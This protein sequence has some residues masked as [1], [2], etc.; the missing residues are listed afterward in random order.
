MPL[1]KGF[2]SFWNEFHQPPSTLQQ[3]KH[4]A[5]VYAEAFTLSRL[6]HAN[7]GCCPLS[8]WLTALQPHSFLITPVRF[9]CRGLFRAC[10]RLGKL[11]AINN[12]V[13]A[14]DSFRQFTN[15]LLAFPGLCRYS[16][17]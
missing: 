10:R 8:V 12:D 7:R 14:V 15:V 17:V 3:T 11:Q 13:S 9:A 2:A 16:S 6:V 4:D 1:W 5:W